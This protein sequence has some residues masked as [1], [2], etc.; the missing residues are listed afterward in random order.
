YK[1]SYNY[2]DLADLIMKKLTAILAFLCFISLFNP[3][4]AQTL[5]SFQEKMDLYSGKF[6]Q[7]KIH[8]QTDR[9]NYGAGET[10]WY[11]IY[12]TIGLENQLSILSNIAYVELISP[13]GEIVSQK[14]NSLFT[15]VSVGDM[16]LADTLVEGSY[17]M[18]AYSNWMRNS[19]SDYYFEKVLNIGNVRSDN[20]IS[21][22]KLI[23]E[24]DN[25]FYLLN[26]EN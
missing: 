13:T 18:R 20:I 25:E 26:F 1:F 12:S 7:E 6:P 9:N 16:L 19:S 15:G 24:A 23:K 22:S 3:L 11:K 14:I 2:K 4:A 5:E 17:R 10:V 21:S 8:I